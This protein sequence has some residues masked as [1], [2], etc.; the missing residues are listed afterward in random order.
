MKALILSSFLFLFNFP[1]ARACN[2]A[3][4]KLDT[5]NIIRHAYERDVFN[6]TGELEFCP[7]SLTVRNISISNPLLKRLSILNV[8]Y[9][10]ETNRVNI[11]VLGRLIGFTPLTVQLY[12]QE[13][14]NAR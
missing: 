8:S 5:L 6:I 14:R 11:T 4:E 9:L 12:F 10:I 3:F 1:I 2:L 13:D 7:P